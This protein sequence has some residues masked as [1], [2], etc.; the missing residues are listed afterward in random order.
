M[1]G[2][3]FVFQQVA[4]LADQELY[5]EGALRDQLLLLQVQLEEGDIEEQDFV[6]RE[7]ELLA[8]LREI[9]ARQRAEAGQEAPAESNVEARRRVIVETPFDE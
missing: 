2:M 1:A 3:R 5:D 6:E 8:R 4:D 9:K 7:A